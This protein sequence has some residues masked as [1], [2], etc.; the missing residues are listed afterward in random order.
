MAQPIEIDPFIKKDL[1][2]VLNKAQKTTVYVA[3]NYEIEKENG[4]LDED[5]A[6]LSDD[7]I[8]FMSKYINENYTLKQ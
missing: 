6:K 4:F 1:L 3:G 8:E 7:I 2:E 5:I